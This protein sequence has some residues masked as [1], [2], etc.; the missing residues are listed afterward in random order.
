MSGVE[1][2]RKISFFRCRNVS[3]EC[4]YFCTNSLEKEKIESII[5]SSDRRNGRWIS[6]QVRFWN[7]K[8]STRAAVLNGKFC[9][10]V[11]IFDW[12]VWV[13][14]IRWCCQELRSR[15]VLRASVHQSH[16]IGLG[17]EYLSKFRKK[18]LILYKRYDIVVKCGI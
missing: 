8:R 12:S 4:V 13:V 10:L 6:K 16:N 14:G 3:L 15:K 7:L 2:Y 17:T 9:A 5:K 11:Q 1:F 18:S